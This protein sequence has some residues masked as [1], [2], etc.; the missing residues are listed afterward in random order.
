MSF[1]KWLKSEVVHFLAAG[2]KYVKV[3][4]S[5]SNPQFYQASIIITI[6]SI[7]TTRKTF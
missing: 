6:P 1:C 4:Q 2:I 3:E 5:S 7:I